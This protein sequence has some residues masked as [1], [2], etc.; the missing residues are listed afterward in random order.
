MSSSILALKKLI[1]LCK[2]ENIKAQVSSCNFLSF[3]YWKK[4]FSWRNSFLKFQKSNA[5]YNEIW[6]RNLLGGRDGCKSVGCS[7]GVPWVRMWSSTWSPYEL[8]GHPGPLRIHLTPL[9][10]TMDLW[11][12]AYFSLGRGLTNR[13]W[14]NVCQNLAR[15]D[16][17]TFNFEKYNFGLVSFLSDGL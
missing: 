3:L 15:Y 9:D 13:V 8:M 17:R 12:T 11:E 5:I 16:C 7:R 10:H 4:S 1:M 2:F 6:K 14:G